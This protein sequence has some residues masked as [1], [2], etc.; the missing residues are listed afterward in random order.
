MNTTARRFFATL[1]STLIVCSSLAIP[2]VAEASHGIK[3]RLV[4]VAPHTY[5]QVCTR[6]V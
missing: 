1:A 5:Q 3:C 2:T 4:Q 6:G